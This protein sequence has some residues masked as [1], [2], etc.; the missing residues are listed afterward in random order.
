MDV[1]DE[2]SINLDSRKTFLFPY[3]DGC[4]GHHFLVE[5]QQRLVVRVHPKRFHQRRGRLGLHVDVAEHEVV[6]VEEGRS[7][8]PRRRAVTVAEQHGPHA[9]VLPPTEERLVV[10][11]INLI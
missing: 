10:L 4:H 5:E 9:V 3:A 1:K 2:V 6:A 11:V 7:Q 8:E